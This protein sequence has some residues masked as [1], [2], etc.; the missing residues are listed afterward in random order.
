[1]TECN[2]HVPG[3][4]VFVL[5]PGPIRPGLASGRSA[6]AGQDFSIGIAKAEPGQDIADQESALPAA[7][8]I[9]PLAQPAFSHLAE[10]LPTFA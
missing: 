2:R 6:G 8:V 4:P 9:L 3:F 5:E 10:K 7:P 1:M